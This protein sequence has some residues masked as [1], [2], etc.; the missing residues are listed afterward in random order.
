MQ[1]GNRSDLI[2]RIIGMLVF[3]VG[4]GLL[5][6]VFYIAYG[7]FTKPAAQALGLILTGDP[8]KDAVTLNYVN[9]G[10]QFGTLLIRLLCLFIMSIASSL[11]ANKGINLYFSAI[12]GTPVH[13]LGSKTTTV[14]PPA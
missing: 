1:S 6:L 3:L 7:L 5:M 2:G 10:V 4:V 14:S 9:L 11:I 13:F 12:Q 8:K